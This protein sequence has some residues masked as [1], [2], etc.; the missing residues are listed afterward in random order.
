[1]FIDI[2]SFKHESMGRKRHWL[3][4]VDEFSDYSHSF[5]LRK[6]T[7]QIVVIPIW[8]KGLK[9]K[10]GIV[11]KNIRLDNSGE[12]RSL[13]KECEKQN[14]GIIFE[15]TAP[16]TPKQNS[17]V[18]RKIPTLMGRSRAMMIHAGFSQ[19][20]KRKFWCEVISTATKLENIMVRKERT[21]PPH[22]LIYN[23]GARYMKYIRSF[24]EMAVIA[25]SDGKK[26]GSKLDTRGRTGIFVG[27]AD[28]HAGMYIDS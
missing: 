28:D 13:Q 24:G 26:M 11:V 18:E 4:V 7:D 27:S 21:K 15:F 23:E 19:Q 12:N 9:T 20:D 14:L 17:V 6:K 22:T 16:G 1:M 10:Y 2:S 5:F 3:I 8:I 25:I